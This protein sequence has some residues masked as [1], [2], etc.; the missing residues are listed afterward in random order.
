MKGK[1][2]KYEDLGCTPK[3]L[4]RIAMKI[5]K[6]HLLL[7][8]SLFLATIMLAGCGCGGG[9]GS[10]STPTSKELTLNIDNQ[11]QLLK[12]IDEAYDVYSNIDSDYAS[13]LNWWSNDDYISGSFV[14]DS[15]IA[16]WNVNDQTSVISL[17]YKNAVFKDIELNGSIH[18][19]SGDNYILSAHLKV[20][21]IS[22]GHTVESDYNSSNSSDFSMT[23]TSSTLGT[24]RIN[25]TDF[26]KLNDGGAH[27]EIIGKDNNKWVVEFYSNV[28][29]VTEPN[30]NSYNVNKDSGAIVQ[31]QVFSGIGQGSMSSFINDDDSATVARLVDNGFT[32]ITSFVKTFKH[33]SYDLNDGFCSDGG[34]YAE[35]SNFLFNVKNCDENGIV[36][37]GDF[38]EEYDN[39]FSNIDLDIHYVNTDESAHLTASNMSLNTST[40]DSHY[41]NVD[42]IKFVGQYSDAQSNNQYVVLKSSHIYFDDQSFGLDYPKSGKILVSTGGKTWTADLHGSTFDLTSPNGT[43]TQHT[44]SLMD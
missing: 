29:V 35:G 24:Y 32:A 17:N 43:T 28:Y 2:I 10:D 20:K 11:D 8:G 22:S 19:T 23:N 9:G 7:L 26:D 40:Y 1:E 18:D 14:T 33:N 21:Q 27:V 4:E 39:K 44:L 25:A 13:V 37:K 38:K 5:L 6:K 34:S 15:G 30:G 31:N 36:L 16:S 3:S 12:V 42:E 41:N